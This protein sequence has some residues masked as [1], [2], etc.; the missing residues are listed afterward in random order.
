MGSSV[1]LLQNIPK[2]AISLKVALDSMPVGI[3]W[4]NLEDQKII[5]TNRKFT[6][7][8]GY[9]AADLDDIP[10]WISKTYPVAED[11]ASAIANWGAYFTAPD[12]FERT[13]D[14]LELRV[15]CKDGTIKTVINSGQILPETGWALATFVDIT[16]RKRDELLVATAERTSRENEAIFHLLLDHSPGMILLAPFDQSRRYISPAVEQI[17][18]FTAVA[19]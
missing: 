9:E 2:D 8:F 11:R 1:V 7:M 18:G 4:A 19:A 13:V 16:E 5:F 12:R 3:S 6:E 17:T 15:L 10:T 14:P